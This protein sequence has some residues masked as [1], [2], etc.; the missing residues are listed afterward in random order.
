MCQAS[1]TDPVLYPP[2]QGLSLA[3]QASNTDSV[4]TPGQ[5]HL[6]ACQVSNTDPVLEWHELNHSRVMFS[7]LLSRSPVTCSRHYQQT[8]YNGSYSYSL[9]Q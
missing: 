6:L 8:H 9:R 2:G 1:N 7:G 5:G 4:I 3:C